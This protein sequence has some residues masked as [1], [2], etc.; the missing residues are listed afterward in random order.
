VDYL[1]SRLGSV[2]ESKV[3]VS[4]MEIYNEKVW[5][6]LE[7]K[8]ADLPIREDINRTIFVPGLSQKTVRSTTEFDAV[9]ELG[10]AHRRTS[11]T[12]LNATSSRSHA[13]LSIVVRCRTDT[14]ASVAKLHLCDLAGSEDNR[15]T[16]NTGMRM[17]ESRFLVVFFNDFN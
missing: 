8:D 7:L 2:L 10:C 15:L 6:L 3:E 5:D 12:S 16:G 9:Y 1:F 11:P 17:T 13:V 14:V 4:Y